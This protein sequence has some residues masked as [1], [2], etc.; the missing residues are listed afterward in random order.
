MSE[1]TEAPEVTEQ[2]PKVA[3]EP[4]PEGNPN[5]EAAKWRKQL[6]EA[7]AGQETANQQIL[8]LQN[9]IITANL[10]PGLKPEAFQLAH[11]NIADLLNPDGSVNLEAVKEA[12]RT[13]AETL[14]VR[15]GPIV[16][17]EGREARIPPTGG[18]DS[19]FAPRRR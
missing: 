3:V 16:S 9:Q 13:A 11:P 19:A 5:H 4:P 12:S 17:T 15:T 18:F 8:A 1:A 14:G 2:A 10:T 6:R 7:Q